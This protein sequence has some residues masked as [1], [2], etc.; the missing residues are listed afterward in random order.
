MEASLSIGQLARAAGVTD[1]TIQF[2]E[3]V[4]VL[5]AA[6]RSASGYRQ[7]SRPDV[8]RLLF[9]RRGCALG[10]SLGDLKV[11]TTELDTKN[12]QSVRPGLRI[13]VTEQLCAVQRQIVEFRALEQQ[14]TSLLQRL[15]TGASRTTH[16][17]RCLD[18]V[19]GD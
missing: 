7:Y 6:R 1:K 9:I 19:A 4:G 11:L 3:Q 18:A 13:I 15:Q 14:L 17:C 5:P 12:C 16:G 8:D 2:Y 10:L